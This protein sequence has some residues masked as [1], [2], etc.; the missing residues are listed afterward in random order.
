MERTSFDKNSFSFAVNNCKSER[1]LE[2]WVAY[3]TALDGCYPMSSIY[4]QGNKIIYQGCEDQGSISLEFHQDKILGAVDTALAGPGFHAA[5]VELLDNIEADWKVSL[6]IKEDY[7][8]RKERDFSKL[9]EQ[10]VQG[11]KMAMEQL[12]GAPEQS[13]LD[14]DRILG[15]IAGD[16]GL[17]VRTEQILTP[18]G[19]F[20]T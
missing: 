19:A 2:E 8:F 6:S 16:R 9:Q 12:M 20:T 14:K 5:A 10:Y 3:L 18:M 17:P 11:L 4:Q 7:G 13:F 1:G 15:P